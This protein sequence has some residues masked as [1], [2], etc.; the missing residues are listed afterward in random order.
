MNEERGQQRRAP[1]Q[2]GIGAVLVATVAVA[3]LFAALR[4]LKVSPQAQYI[5]LAVLAVS[6][7]AALGLLVAIAGSVTGHRDDD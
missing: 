1:L 3:S 7:I 2:F 6:V 5:V 4:W